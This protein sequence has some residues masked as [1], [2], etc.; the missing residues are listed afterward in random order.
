MAHVS[1]NRS[2]R[3]AFVSQR[4]PGRVSEH[5]RRHSKGNPCVLAGSLD[6][7]VDGCSRDWP[8]TLACEDKSSLGFLSKPAQE[9][10]FIALDGVGRRCAALEPRD[11]Q[12]RAPKIDLVPLEVDEL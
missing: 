7:L 10:E 6:E 11:V 4:E 8:A 3:D 12:P 1:L 5:V 9:S 2:G